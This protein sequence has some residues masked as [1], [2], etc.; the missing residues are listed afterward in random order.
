MKLTPEQL[1]AYMAEFERGP[2]WARARAAA[3][4]SLATM[5]RE[6][7]RATCEQLKRERGEV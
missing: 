5:W 7:E 2:E 6:A 4:F 1:A 3:R